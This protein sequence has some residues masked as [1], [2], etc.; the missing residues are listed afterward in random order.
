MTTT[1]TN[2][3]DTGADAKDLTPE[4]IVE[5]H[6]TGRVYRCP[7]HREAG[8]MTTRQSW[9]HNDAVHGTGR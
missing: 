8:W 3:L 7:Q 2:G 5:M 9:D 6:R 4:E 1:R